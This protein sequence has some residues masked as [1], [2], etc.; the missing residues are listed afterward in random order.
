MVPSCAIHGTGLSQVHCRVGQ[1]RWWTGEDRDS[2]QSSH[3]PSSSVRG[4]QCNGADL[5][6]WGA[7]RDGEQSNNLEVRI[8][9]IR[10]NL[11]LLAAGDRWSKWGTLVLTEV[12][13]KT[14][15][16]VQYWGTMAR[17]ISALSGARIAN[18]WWEPVYS[19]QSILCSAQTW[20][21]CYLLLLPVDGRLTFNLAHYELY[22]FA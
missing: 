8:R 19:I 11:C 2:C 7:S 16:N 20:W 15:H 9:G 14:R 17:E 13:T 21:L 6:K 5:L 18:I 12:V 3:L 4:Q 22:W 1:S 10:D